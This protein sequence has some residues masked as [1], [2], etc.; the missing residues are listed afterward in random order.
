VNPIDAF[1]AG[2]A[3]F[4]R[5]CYFVDMNEE[6]VVLY[7]RCF[8]LEEEERDSFL[9][10]WIDAFLTRESPVNW[11]SIEERHKLMARINETKTSVVSE[12]PSRPPF[13]KIDDLI[14]LDIKFCIVGIVRG[15]SKRGDQWYLK[16]KF[17]KGI[18]FYLD[19]CATTMLAVVSLSTGIQQRDALLTKLKEMLPIHGATFRSIQT[20]HG[21]NYYDLIDST[22]DTFCACQE[23]VLLEAPIGDEEAY[24]PWSDDDDN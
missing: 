21:G 19:A 13:V 9:T 17:Q 8:Q 4:K 18:A 20:S 12:G 16:L 6:A 10:G 1:F 23:E 3:F 11:I 24:N 22:P 2:A 7:G 5:F 15:S 14:Q